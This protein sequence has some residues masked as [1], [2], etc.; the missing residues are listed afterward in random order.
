MSEGGAGSQ[1]V[2]T[3]FAAGLLIAVLSMAIVGSHIALGSHTPGIA[4]TAAAPNPLPA[5]WRAG[6]HSLARCD[7]CHA[8]DDVPGIGQLASTA[9]T[10]RRDDG[11]SVPDDARRVRAGGE[12]YRRACAGCHAATDD[13]STRDGT[14]PPMTLAR[15]GDATRSPP[16]AGCGKAGPALDDDHSIAASV[17]SLSDDEIA[18]LAAFL[19]RHAPAPPLRRERLRAT[20]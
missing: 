13:R 7:A 4:T 16:L 8:A 19:Q 2:R 10:P 12:V 6:L 14:R 5:K 17:T 15:Y 18:A 11:V 20:L 3:A 1:R 9:S